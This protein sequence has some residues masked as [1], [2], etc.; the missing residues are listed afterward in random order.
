[1]RTVDPMAWNSVHLHSRVLPARRWTKRVTAARTIPRGLQRHS[2]ATT[3]C[4]QRTLTLQVGLKHGAAV[5]DVQPRRLCRARARMR[6]SRPK[7]ELLLTA[8]RIAADRV[9]SPRLLQVP[10]AGPWVIYHQGPPKRYVGGVWYLEDEDVHVCLHRCRNGNEKSYCRPCKLKTV[11]AMSCMTSRT[12]TAITQR[13]RMTSAS[14]H[15][16]VV[17]AAPSVVLVSSPA[18]RVRSSLGLVALP[19]SLQ[20]VAASASA[21]PNDSESELTWRGLDGG[22]I[23][24]PSF[25]VTDETLLDDASF[26]AML[27]AGPPT[28][29]PVPAPTRPT[30]PVPIPAHPP[31]LSRS[32][33]FLFDGPRGLSDDVT[34]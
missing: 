16:T 32:D 2:C 3:R 31:R 33:S 13:C 6:L 7:L 21:A 12:A 17:I 18:R 25:F 24:A 23:P 27:A 28:A 22:E 29:A 1:M 26:V 19:V 11:S 30:R 20:H 14:S 34:V 8:M 9:A 15:A 4:R 10:L 5:E